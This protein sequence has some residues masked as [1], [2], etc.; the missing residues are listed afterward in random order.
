MKL[1]KNSWLYS[2]SRRA[3]EIWRLDLQPERRPSPAAPEFRLQQLQAS[4]AYS[5]LR[6]AGLTR[7]CELPWGCARAPKGT[8]A[9]GAASAGGFTDLFRTKSVILLHF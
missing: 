9:T 8:P 5:I 6:T 1:D 3:T 7:S 2:V 4:G